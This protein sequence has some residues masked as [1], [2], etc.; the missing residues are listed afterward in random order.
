MALAVALCGFEPDPDGRPQPDPPADFVLLAVVAGLA[1][2]AVAGRVV[3]LAV[4][5][6]VRWRLA[7]RTRVE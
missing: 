4:E 5:D 2:G 3:R 6:A 1:L 7:R